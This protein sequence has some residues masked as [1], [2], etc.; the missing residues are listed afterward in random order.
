MGGLSFLRP[1]DRSREP[2]ACPLDHWAAPDLQHLKQDACLPDDFSVLPF[3]VD[4]SAKPP[5]PAF[6][7][8]RLLL[9]W[10]DIRSQA[11]CEFR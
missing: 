11:F 7:H 4:E 5:A 3:F 1:V 9:S 10:C 6:S 2:N 8:K